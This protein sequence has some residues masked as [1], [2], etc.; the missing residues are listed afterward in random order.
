MPNAAEI[1]LYSLLDL[2]LNKT[3][4]GFAGCDEAKRIGRG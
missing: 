1:H 3:N 4:S 2:C